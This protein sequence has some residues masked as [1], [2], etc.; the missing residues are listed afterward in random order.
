MTG[1]WFSLRC[2]DDENQSRRTIHKLWKKV[3]SCVEKF[4]YETGSQRN[5]LKK[6]A[7]FTKWH[8]KRI[9][10]LLV[11]CAAIMKVH[12]PEGCLKR[13]N[14]RILSILDRDD[15]IAKVRKKSVELGIPITNE[16]KP[17]V[18]NI[19]RRLVNKN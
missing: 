19:F 8:I 10:N 13:V 17:D 4:G 16:G 5:Y 1:E 9:I 14:N 18:E 2:L 12:D 11:S 6:K 15:F 3:Q 7:E